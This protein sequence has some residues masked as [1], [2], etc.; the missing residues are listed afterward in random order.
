MKT[1]QHGIRLAVSSACLL[2][3]AGLLLTPQPAGALTSSWITD[4]N[5]YWSATGNWNNGVP[6]NAGDVALLTNAVGA[7]RTITI[8]TNVIVGTIK[9]GGSTNVFVLSLGTGGTLTFDSGSSSNALLQQNTGSANR[10]SAP[11]SG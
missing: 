8:D 9:M 3:V 11:Q 4:G 10:P 2:A 1:L 5:G 6:M 7:S